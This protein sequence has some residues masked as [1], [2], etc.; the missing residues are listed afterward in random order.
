MVTGNKFRIYPTGPQAQTLLRWIGCQRFIYNAKVSED[1]YFRTFARKSLAHAGE[2][3]PIDQQYAQFKTELTPWLDEVPS[4]ILR[5]GAVLWKQAYG[6]FFRQLGGRPTTRKAHGRQSV[7]ITS[8]LFEFVPETDVASGEISYRLLIGTKK[9]PVGEV[10]LNAHHAFTPP[11]SIHISVHAG[12]WHVGFTTDD[13]VPEVKDEETAEWLASFTEEELAAATV[14]IDRGVAIKFAGSNGV[15]YDL[16]VAQKK[17]IERLACRKRRYQRHLARQVKGSNRRE[18]TKHHIARID[19][20]LADMRHD[21][22]HQTSRRIVDD[23][24]ALLIVFEAL[25]VRNMTRSAQGTMDKPGKNVRQKAGLNRSILGAAWGK[26][27]TFARYKARRAGKL[28]I[29][30][31]PHFSSQECGHCGHIHPGNRPSQ[32]AFAC[33]CCG[34]ESHADRNAANVIAKRGVAQVL[35][36]G[37]TGSREPVP[38]QSGTKA[39]RGNVSRGAVTR[40]TPSPVKRETPATTQGV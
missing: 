16:S 39:R 9:F 31:P 18:R 24:R 1:R 12:R 40:G 33:Q 36:P 13:G 22:A 10:R 19:Q 7:W 2:L 4:V 17:R 23:P 11:A 37:P 15:D 14:G 21:F 3:A 35:N 8:E 6:R 34:Y 26:T 27:L 29:E 20:K 38:E 25:K 32:A 5:N 28:C 30:V